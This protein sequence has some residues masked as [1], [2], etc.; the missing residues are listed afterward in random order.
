M[1]EAGVAEEL[2]AL[3]YQ[4]TPVIVIGDKVIVGYNPRKLAEAIG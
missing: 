3:G 2:F 1:D 4:V